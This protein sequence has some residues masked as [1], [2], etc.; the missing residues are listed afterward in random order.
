MPPDASRTITQL[1]VQSRNS[2]R[3]SVFV[4]GEF[5]FGIHGALVA[6][7]G[8]AEGQ[9]LP[10]DKEEALRDDE[11]LHQAKQRALTYLAHKPRTE[12]EVRTKLSENDV[13]PA[14]IDPVIQ[15][16][17]DLGYVDDEAYATD[18]VRNRF[19]SKKYGPRR[20]ARELVQRGIDRARAERAVDAF[21]DRHDALAAARDHADKRWPRI[22]GDGDSRRQ[23]QKLYRYLVRRGFTADTVYQVLDETVGR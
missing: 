13:A 17:Q 12:Q 1:S 8:L 10:A 3:V 23:K 5:A 4:D 11:S 20:L 21:F 14:I 18:Y 22:K 15:R 16:L 6:K 2:D 9:A 7:H 19:A